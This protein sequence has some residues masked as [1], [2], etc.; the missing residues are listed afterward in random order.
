[1]S[2]KLDQSY[3]SS[4][5]FHTL[6]PEAVGQARGNF[7]NMFVLHVQALWKNIC[8][9]FTLSTVCWK[10]NLKKI[11]LQ[12]RF[13]YSMYPINVHVLFFG[14]SYVQSNMFLETYLIKYI[15]NTAQCKIAW[16]NGMCEV[17]STLKVMFFSIKNGKEK[18]SDC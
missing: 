15:Q 6:S 9:I 18:V 3:E 8:P 11:F 10:F 4:K 14:S 13:T 17:R 16:V 7:F 12:I 5:I 1:M 2:F